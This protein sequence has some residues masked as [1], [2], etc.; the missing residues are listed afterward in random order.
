MSDEKIGRNAPAL[1]EQTLAEHGAWD[2]VSFLLTSHRLRQVEYE[3]WR[4]G[5]TPCLEDA[6]AGNKSR[7][8]SLL[9]AAMTHALSMGLIAASVSWQG[10]GARAGQTLR[11]FHDDEIN[12]R[13]QLRISPRSDRPQLDL[14]MDAPHTLLLNQLRQALLD[15]SP[16]IDT[17]FERAFD[18]IPNEPAL[19]RLDAIR[20][21]MRDAIDEPVARFRY[22]DEVI[23]PVAAD[24]FP[25][26]SLDIMA[27][28]WRSTA[29]AISPLP[30][31]PTLSVAHASEAWMRAHA[32]E[33][34]IASI[35]HTPD[36]HQHLCLHE[37]RI[38]ALSCMGKHDSVRR[39]WMLY[40]WLFP[41]RAA[42]ALDSADLKHCGL[43]R[44]WRQFSQQEQA[45]PVDDFPALIALHFSGGELSDK[46]FESAHHTSGWLHY[47][48]ACKLLASESDGAV[49]LELRHALKKANPWLLR[50]FMA[51]RLRQP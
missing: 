38:V 18:E 31:D 33:A 6:L 39:A 40:C 26:R 2:V 19:A 1:V 12:Q 49:N 4:M 30:F 8:L 32:W 44:L 42:I 46:A 50:V 47:S 13:F 51:T 45:G 3:A 20:A 28:L 34:C 24:E 11:L 16:V 41:D 15:R 21:V 5:N 29:E 36:W 37:R 35:E 25:R 9:E 17:L 7:I 14:F 48:I 27:P 22:L 43:Q 23:A 10:W